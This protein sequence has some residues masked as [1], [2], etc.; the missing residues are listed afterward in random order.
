M[1]C[2]YHFIHSDIALLEV[3]GS[4]G[5]TIENGQYCI[6]S[7]GIDTTWYANGSPHKGCFQYYH[8]RYWYEGQGHYPM[9][10]C[11]WIDSNGDEFMDICGMFCENDVPVYYSGYGCGSHY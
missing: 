7:D 5:W 10:C 8:E 2:G 9:L 4:W 1:W 11:A 3:G 6:Q